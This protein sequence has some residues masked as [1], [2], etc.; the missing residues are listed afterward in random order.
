MSG[1]LRFGVRANFLLSLAASVSWPWLHSVATELFLTQ[2]AKQLH[3][4]RLP[5]E[6]LTSAGVSKAARERIRGK[7]RK[8]LSRGRANMEGKVVLRPWIMDHGWK[9]PTLIRRLTFGARMTSD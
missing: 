6:Q 7:R 4:C 3:R 5:D 9:P 2:G 1:P 8:K